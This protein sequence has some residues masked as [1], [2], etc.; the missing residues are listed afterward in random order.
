MVILSIKIPFF[1]NEMKN[2]Q[3][4]HWTL[5]TDD[6]Y[7]NVKVELKYYQKLLVLKKI[8]INGYTYEQVV[9]NFNK[10]RILIS[11]NVFDEK[12]ILNLLN[13]LTIYTSKTMTY[14]K[15]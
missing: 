14:S 7:S 6:T 2:D 12:A 11:Q 5:I 4:F 1:S 8:K 10:G 3:A 15:S 13:S 9:F